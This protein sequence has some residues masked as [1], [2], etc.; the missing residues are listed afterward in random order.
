MIQETRDRV[1]GKGNMKHETID[2][3]QVMLDWRHE[4]GVLIQETGDKRQDTRD[5]RQE[6]G[7]KIQEM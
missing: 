4:T 1:W 5:R 6:T 2:F 3:R 7:E